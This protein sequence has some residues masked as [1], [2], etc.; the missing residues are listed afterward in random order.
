MKSPITLVLSV[1]F[2]LVAL[3]YAF[4]SHFAWGP[5]NI[6]KGDPAS[7]IPSTTWEETRSSS[8]SAF[9]PSTGNTTENISPVDGAVAY[10]KDISRLELSGTPQDQLSI[11]R[12]LTK[13]LDA[14]RILIALPSASINE[15]KDSISSFRANLIATQ[16]DCSKV[17]RE[18]IFDRFKYLNSA[19]AAKLPEA[20]IDYYR[21]GPSGQPEDLI[22]RPDDLGVLEWKRN[23]IAGLTEAAATGNRDSMALLS[24]IFSNREDQVNFNQEM[25]VA[26]LMLLQMSR[27]IGDLT[28]SK[29]RQ[30]EIERQTRAMSSDQ[31][32]RAELLSQSLF[33]KCCQRRLANDH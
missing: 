22:T 2:I 17:P 26:Y 19:N 16:Q 12:L 8:P 18:K 31:I 15:A 10:A 23:A 21:A 20:A 4:D 28:A 1:T 25:S 5:Q 30:I 9:T 29:Y 33:E 13:C 3:I 7:A 32:K 24:D 6:K 14:E 27:P 11:F